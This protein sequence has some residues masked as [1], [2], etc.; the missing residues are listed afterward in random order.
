VL[1]THWPIRLLPFAVCIPI[2]VGRL[3]RHRRDPLSWTVVLLIAAVLYGWASDH[4]NQGRMISPAALYLQ[5]ALAIWVADRLAAP[6]PIPS[7]VRHGSRRVRTAAVLMVAIVAAFVVPSAAVATRS[8]VFA[9]L[10]ASLLARLPSVL[11]AELDAPDFGWAS[12][13]VGQ[14]DVTM[15]DD[16]NASRFAAV[17]SKV[18]WDSNH[19]DA[20][21]PAAEAT[22]REETVAEFYEPGTSPAARRAAAQRVG[23]QRA[24]LVVGEAGD[25]LGPEVCRSRRHRIV[26]VD[27]GVP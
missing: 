16:G 24:L 25:G 2:L 26:Q 11:G 1:Y 4:F 21:M 3:R 15:V 17:A 7:V 5:I 20:L 23:A 19:P 13:C 12:A 18:V 14:Y 8:A 9:G 22:L 10:P 27:A 6:D